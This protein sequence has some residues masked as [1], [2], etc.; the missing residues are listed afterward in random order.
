MPNKKYSGRLC[1]IIKFKG[2]IYWEFAV[3]QES[4]HYFELNGDLSNNKFLRP[5]RD[6]LK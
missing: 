3:L 2:F 4:L 6:T 5:I 1:R